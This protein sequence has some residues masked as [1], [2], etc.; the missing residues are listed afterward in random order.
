MH[1]DHTFS[2]MRAQSVRLIAIEEVQNYG[3]IVYIKN[4]F[5][6]GW[7]RMHAPRP[8]PLD[9]PLA[10]S[11]RNHQKGLAYF[12]HLAPLILLFFTK[13]RCQK[14]GRAWPNGRPAPKYATGT[15]NLKLLSKK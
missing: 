10:I 8:T 9:P 12:S 14:G 1:F 4:V 5:E 7:W 3:K 13:K 11:Y 6:N 2:I 15:S